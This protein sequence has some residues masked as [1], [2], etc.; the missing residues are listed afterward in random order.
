MLTIKDLVANKEMTKQA[1]VAVLG[2]HHGIGNYR[3]FHN[4]PWRRTYARAF[5]LY[6]RKGGRIY[7][8][9]QY[10]FTWKR[11]Q[12]YHRGVLRIYR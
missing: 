4:G 5:R 6:V 8:A 2:G 11:V 12:A 1:M 3:H 9:V 10:Q 7:R